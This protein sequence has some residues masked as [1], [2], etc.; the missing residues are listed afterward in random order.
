MKKGFTMAEVLITLGIIGIIAAMTIP[1]VMGRYREK[2]TVARLKK[3]YAALATANEVMVMEHSPYY[4]CKECQYNLNTAPSSSDFKA[5]IEKDFI[6][7]LNVIQKCPVRGKGCFYSGA[8]GG[9]NS[10]NYGVLITN[11]SYLLQDGTAIQFQVNGNTSMDIIVDLNGKNG[12]NKYGIDT[13]H[14]RIHGKPENVKGKLL[15]GGSPLDPLAKFQPKCSKTET[16]QT[17]TCAAW[18]LTYENME[19]LHCNDL[20]W[21]KK[22]KCN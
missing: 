6:K 20:E 2:A 19:Y 22:I 3:V 5:N 4:T 16:Q 1:S 8:Y 18:V 9:L 7:R 14:F 12:P 17:V 11:N 15:P 10:D 21:D 13:F